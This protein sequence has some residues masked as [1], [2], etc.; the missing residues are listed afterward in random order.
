MKKLI[1]I[2]LLAIPL[3]KAADPYEA[4]NLAIERTH[5]W[6][7]LDYL[8]LV[9]RKLQIVPDFE[10]NV[11]RTLSLND[12]LLQEVPNFQNLPLLEILSLSNNRLQ[13]F[14]SLSNLLLLKKLYL[15]ENQIQDIPSNLNLL[16]VELISLR[17]NN[18]NQIAE[19]KTLLQ[20]FPNLGKLDLTGND[21][22]DSRSVQDL[23]DAATEANRNIRIIADNILPEGNDNT[24]NSF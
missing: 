12:N 23:R 17:F 4:W 14:P 15:D 24:V 10:H 9:S 18:I 20:Q 3:C 11:V 8:N 7:Q 13:D 19:P 22:L 2:F 21:Q 5:E 16:Q 1:F 6:Q